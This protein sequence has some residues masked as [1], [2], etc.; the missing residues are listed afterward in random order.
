[1]PDLKGIIR[2]VKLVYLYR[3]QLDKQSGVH[4]DCLRLHL[5][6]VQILVSRRRLYRLEVE[7][8]RPRLN[9]AEGQQ[10]VEEKTMMM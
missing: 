10:P 3:E 4:Q 6:R 7:I 8:M 9:R 5:R 1:M 2:K